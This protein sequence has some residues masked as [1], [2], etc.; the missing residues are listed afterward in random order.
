VRPK[1]RFTLQDDGSTKVEYLRGK[2]S[3]SRVYKEMV[4]PK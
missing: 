1:V 2:C 3:K 4:L